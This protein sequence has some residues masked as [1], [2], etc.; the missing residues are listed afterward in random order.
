MENITN[1]NINV[2]LIINELDVNNI[3]KL[4]DVDLEIIIKEI[5]SR[6]WVSTGIVESGCGVYI[7]Y[8]EGDFTLYVGQTGDS[9]HK[10]FASED[11]KL[12]MN[13]LNAFANRIE[14]Y[15]IENVQQRL[16]FERIQIA[17][18]R[19]I[20]NSD[21]YDY[22]LDRD[23]NNCDKFQ[24]I[25]LC[26]SKYFEVFNMDILDEKFTGKDLIELHNKIISNIEHIKIDEK[27]KYHNLIINSSINKKDV[28][29]KDDLEVFYEK[30][31]LEYSPL[32][33]INR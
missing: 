26:L 7:I 11:H 13:F 14:F 19:P 29:T 17:N 15:H 31:L 6:E 21:K 27:S 5:V 33:L 4:K 1:I 9:F 30:L 18:L 20:I 16:L 3:P 12:K 8:G 25:I 10:R 32:K 2:K 22:L 24:N 23:Y 28:L